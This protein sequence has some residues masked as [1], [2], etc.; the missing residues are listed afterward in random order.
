M[1]IPPLVFHYNALWQWNP[2]TNSEQDPEYCPQNDVFFLPLF[3]LLLKLFY[4]RKK[5]F[6][7][8]HA[9]FSLHFHSAVFVLFLIFTLLGMLFHPLSSLF[10]N[11]G[12]ILA[13]IYL[14]IDLAL[15]LFYFAGICDCRLGRI[16]LRLSKNS[17]Y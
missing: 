3:A 14:I 6:Y 1:A 7:V 16:A 17:M 2:G 8:D 4:N 10:S 15:Q 5:Y 11:L 13:F 12:M 9:I